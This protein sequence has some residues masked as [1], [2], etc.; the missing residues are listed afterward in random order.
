MRR[1][2]FKFWDLVRLILE[3]LRYFGLRR[4]QYLWYIGVFGR[5]KPKK[6]TSNG[7]NESTAYY[8]WNLSPLILFQKNIISKMF[9][10]YKAKVLSLTAMGLVCVGTRRIKVHS[11]RSIGMWK[12][13]WLTIE[14]NC[15]KRLRAC[16]RHSILSPAVCPY[17]N[18]KHARSKEAG[19]VITTTK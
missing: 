14:N 3:T 8:L 12:K 2:A 1:E 18:R 6:S 7:I 13:I 19:S 10:E 11:F 17:V 5:C 4:I 15:Q 9:Y 16:N